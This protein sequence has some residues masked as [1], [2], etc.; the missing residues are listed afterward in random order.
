M[1]F[2]SVEVLQCTCVLLV[3]KFYSVQCILLDSVEVLQ[4]TCILPMLTFYSVHVFCWI[5]LKSE[6]RPWPMSGCK[7]TSSFW[8][9]STF[10]F[11]K[12]KI[13]QQHNTPQAVKYDN[14]EDGQRGNGLNQCGLSFYG[15]LSGLVPDLT[16]IFLNGWRHCADFNEGGVDQVD[17][18]NHLSQRRSN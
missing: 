18:N 6:R 10:S 3:F 15:Q 2:A 5:V 9:W 7:T 4:C 13:K 17:I 12:T 14:G 1:Y 11:F 16:G 8:F